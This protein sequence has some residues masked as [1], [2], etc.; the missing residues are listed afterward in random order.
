MQ[1]VLECNNWNCSPSI[2]FPIPLSD[3][4]PSIS[5]SQSVSIL[6]LC[7][8]CTHQILGRH[9]PWWCISNTI[10]TLQITYVF[11]SISACRC[12]WHD[13]KCP[14]L[15]TSPA[16][17]SFNSEASDKVEDRYN[18][19]QTCIC[20]NILNEVLL[21]Y[22]AIGCWNL[23]ILEDSAPYMTKPAGDVFGRDIL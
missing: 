9:G 5:L 4:F 16:A 20:E 15:D 8:P 21:C 13:G 11:R 18:V 12:K 14:A 10:Y 2:P 7:T 3:A 17:I 23:N 1:R 19:I 6:P 22:V